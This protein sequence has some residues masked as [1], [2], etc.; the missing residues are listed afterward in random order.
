MSTTERYPL[1]E[2]L[3]DAYERI[4]RLATEPS[5]CRVRGI[6]D[7]LI[8]QRGMYTWMR[9]VGSCMPE[10]GPRPSPALHTAGPPSP[11]AEREL[12][13]TIASIITGASAASRSFTSS[14][15]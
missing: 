13:N 14:S 4:R 2:T 11:I 9:T 15:W 8:M 1:N 3:T 5:D 7:G 12:V 10:A 6:G